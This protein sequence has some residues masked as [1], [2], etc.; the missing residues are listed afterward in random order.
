MNNS[1]HITG[2]SATALQDETGPSQRNDAL[3]F[4]WEQPSAPPIS[5]DAAVTI[6]ESFIRAVN[7]QADKVTAFDLPP[8]IS[9]DE[10][11]EAHATPFCVVDDWF[12]ADVGVFIAPGGTGK[13]TLVL[14][15]SIHIVLGLELFGY[16]VENPGPVIIV[17][18]EDSREM[19]VARL[20]GIARQM[21]LTEEQ[22]RIVRQ[23]II[24]ADVS[25]AGFKLTKVERDVVQPHGNVDRLI[26][27]ARKIYPEIVFIDPAVSFGVGES[28]VNDAEQGL[29]EAARKIRNELGCAVVYIHHTGKEAAKQGATHQY[30]GRGGSAF[31]D[32]SRMVHVLARL[33][34]EQ[35]LEAT[36]DMLNEG[37]HGLVLARPKISHAPPQP[38]IY[39]KRRGYV[40]ERHDKA[41][42]ANAVLEA[43]ATKVLELLKAEVA[44][45]RYPSQNSV[46]PLAREQGIKTAAFR[47]A[48]AWLKSSMRISE[49]PL[50]T[51]GRGG[52]RSYLRPVD[53][54]PSITTPPAGN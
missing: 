35:W 39:I 11:H 30:A 33:D 14:F 32:G 1:E 43:N 34:E 40:F 8:P 29:I 5:K 19:L 52:A 38:D 53:P 23:N 9:E 42:G 21:G 31:A 50:T 49:T 54:M 26:A 3:G 6:A 48:I 16:T 44:A 2:P 22:M 12:Y 25:G 24:I 28:R 13:T 51:G 46:A 36:G 15:E 47:E 45:G 41:G 17:T 37:E 7:E 18:A 20:R 27:A 4:F 10:W